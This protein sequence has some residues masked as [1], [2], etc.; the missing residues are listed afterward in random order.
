MACV[1]GHKHKFGGT[2]HFKTVK[3]KTVAIKECHWCG[4]EK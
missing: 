1:N 2:G 4:K 3:G